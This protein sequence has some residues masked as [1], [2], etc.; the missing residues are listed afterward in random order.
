[1]EKPPKFTAQEFYDKTRSNEL[2]LSFSSISRL[3]KSP[4]HFREY[5]TEPFKQTPSIIWGQ[6]VHTLVL[7]PEKYDQRYLVQPENANKSSN[8]NKAVLAQFEAVLGNRTP[9][10][11]K[12][13]E[14]A[15]AVVERIYSKP[16]YMGGRAIDLSLFLQGEKEKRFTTIIDEVPFIGVVD[17]ENDFG[18]TDLKSTADA[19]CRSFARKAIWDF[20]YHLQAHI[21]NRYNNKA[22]FILAFDA[23]GYTSIHT[24]GEYRMQEAAEKLKMLLDAYR[25]LCIE[26][27]ENPNIWDLEYEYW[28]GGYNVIK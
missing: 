13:L 18:I 27:L 3:A 24:F 10:T 12:Q 17:V 2:V 22:F 21:Y 8:K 15:K 16:F 26:S 5:F 28:N 7:E 25:S 14:T 6:L 4:R 9:I 1:M 19:E 23:D 20:N 11:A